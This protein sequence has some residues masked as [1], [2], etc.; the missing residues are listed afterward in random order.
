MLT[1]ASPI[2]STSAVATMYHRFVE[3]S[4]GTL[5]GRGNHEN[6]TTGLAFNTLLQTTAPL[7]SSSDSGGEFHL[8]GQ[9]ADS[10][11]SG[12]PYYVN[13]RVMGVLFGLIHLPLDPDTS[14]TS[15][16]Y[17]L[18]R[19]LDMIGYRTTLTIQ[20]NTYTTGTVG[21]AFVTPDRDVCAYACERWSSCVI[22]THWG[23]MCSLLTTN[24]GSATIS[25]ATSG[26]K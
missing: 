10:G 14:Y 8:D 5:V 1:L 3:D 21:S 22:F 18:P 23:G 12:G 19:I 9:F 16:P 2:P 20:P 6:G 11:D 7:E 24:T 26:V 4:T 15:V 17:H 13:G 25:G